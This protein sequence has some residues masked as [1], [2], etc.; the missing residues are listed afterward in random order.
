MKLVDFPFPFYNQAYSH[1]LNTSGRQ[2]GLYFFQVIQGDK[3]VKL[4]YNNRLRLIRLS[5][6][7]GGIYDRNGVPLA[8][9]ETTFCIMGYPLDLDKQGMLPHVSELL[10]RHGIPM[11]VEDLEQTIKKQRWAPYRVIRLVPN[12]TMAQM[13]E[14]VLPSQANSV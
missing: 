5:P 4:A 1:R 6:P 12:L 7:R 10:S 9:N 3:Y 11:S 8:V 14:L 13:A 2:C